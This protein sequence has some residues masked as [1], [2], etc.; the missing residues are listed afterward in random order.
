MDKFE[1]GDGWPC[2]CIPEH[3]RACK[4]GDDFVAVIADDFGLIVSVRIVMN[5]C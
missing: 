2:V 4:V 3:K 1:A 5:D